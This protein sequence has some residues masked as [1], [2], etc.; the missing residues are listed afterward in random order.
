MADRMPPST[1]VHDNPAAAAAAGNEAAVANFARLQ[2][3]IERVS[4]AEWIAH[5]ATTV[6]LLFY[7]P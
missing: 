5:L 1:I 7:N 6:W 3:W 4:K 2:K